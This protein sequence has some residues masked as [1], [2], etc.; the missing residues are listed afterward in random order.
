MSSFD[1][2]TTQKKS[3]KCLDCHADPKTLGFGEGILIKV[4]GEWRFRATFDSLRS[5]FSF[6]F[7]LDAFGDLTGKHLHTGYRRGARPFNKDEL[8]G[9]ILNFNCCEQ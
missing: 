8:E 5:G 4:E 9:H 6:S 3:R 2:H 1:P 7:P